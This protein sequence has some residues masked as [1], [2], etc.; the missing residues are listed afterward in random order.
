MPV[1][2]CVT[3]SMLEF[4]KDISN[5]ALKISVFPEPIDVLKMLSLFPS[6]NGYSS[7]SYC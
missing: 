4:A 3:M 7:S 5:S 6:S 2:H 1:C